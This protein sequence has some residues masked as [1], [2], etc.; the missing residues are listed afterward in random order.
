MLKI[1]GFF[2][3]FRERVAG[4]N[5]SGSHQ[6]L[7]HTGFNYTLA[8]THDPIVR[9]SDRTLRGVALAYASGGGRLGH[10]PRL[11]QTCATTLFHRLS[12]CRNNSEPVSDHRNRFR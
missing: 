7:T 11:A 10:A 8:S 9:I 6:F 3:T 1:E 12:S 4:V 2:N 5:M